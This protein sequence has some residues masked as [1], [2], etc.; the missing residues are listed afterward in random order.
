V[1]SR[2]VGAPGWAERSARLLVEIDRQ[3]DDPGTEASPSEVPVSLRRESSGW[4]VLVDDRWT[5]LG[6]KKGY[7]QLALLLANP[8]RRMH[9]SQLADVPIG[10]GAS[11]VL[12]STALQR[13]RARF[14]ELEAAQERADRRGD[15]ATSERLAAEQRALEREVRSSRGLGG[16]TRALGSDVERVRVNVTRTIRHAITDLA[17]H[18][19]AAAAHLDSTVHTGTYCSYDPEPPA[20]PTS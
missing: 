2:Q 20:G 10:A 1:L 17:A 14:T 11:P 15:A 16:R 7:R 19:P 9:V 13:F 4:S 8:G 5:P 12:D 6:N 18:A 3:L